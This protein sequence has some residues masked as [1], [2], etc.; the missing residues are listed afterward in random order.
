MDGAYVFGE[1]CPQYIFLTRE[2]LNRPKLEG[3][4]YICSPP[5]R[6]VATQEA[7]WRHIAGGTFSVVSSD[8]AP[9]RFDESGKF[10]NG[11]D[12]DFRGFANGMPGIEMRLPLMFS[13]GVL[14][15][16]ISVN[17]FVG[18]SS[19]NAARLYGMLPRKG[20]LAVGADADIAI[21]D[22]NENR[23]AGE[24][25]DAMDYN[26]FEGMNITGWPTTVVSR[27]QRIIDNGLLRAKPGDGAFIHR[28]RTDLSGLAGTSLPE[29]EAKTNF[30]VEI[31]K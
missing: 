6:D 24:M 5:L 28:G 30:G 11:R 7:L 15:G 2:D 20:T 22:P 29:T 8:H 27:G 14:K 1:T 31:F 12:V 23:V 10:S 25:H 18:L 13:E 4:K 21:W 26:P 19:T 9:Y 16:K 3:A 17:Q